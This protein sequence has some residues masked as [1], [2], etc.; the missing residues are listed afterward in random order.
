MRLTDAQGRPLVQSE[1]NFV[2]PRL[3][4]DLGL[5]IDP[6]LLFKSKEAR[7]RT[8][9][10]LLIEVFARAIRAQQNGD[11]SE[12]DRLVD[13]PEVDEIGFGYSAKRIKGSGMGRSLNRLVAETLAG[14]PALL[15]RGVHHLEEL[16]LLSTHI[17]PDRISDMT[18][19]ILKEELARYTVEQCGL[20]D[21]PVSSGVPLPHVFDSESF[22]WRDLY[23]DLPLDPST[24]RALLFVP[25]RMVRVLPWINY[26]EYAN[27]EFRLFLRAAKE[28]APSRLQGGRRGGP[29]KLEVVAITRRRLDVLDQYVARKEREQAAAEPDLGAEAPVEPRAEALVRELAEIP[30][31]RENA[32]RYQRTTLA[33]L[34]HL[35][36]PELT[37]GRL[38]QATIHGT[39]RRDIVFTNESDKSFWQYVRLS[40][41]N[42]LVMF[43][44]KNVQAVTNPHINQVAT[45]LG[46]RIGRFGV[47]L[48]RKPAQR[49]QVLKTISVFN[50]SS[51]RKVVLVIHDGDLERML[52]MKDRGV[53]PT[54]HIQELYRE[55][56][57]RLQ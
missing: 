17:G 51:P 32:S 30:P 40:Y 36:E 31:G 38:E 21:I 16:Q 9:H 18:A 15:E 52:R 10:D 13:F 44:A 25:R 8:F 11:R 39:E 47:I 53:A 19:N 49:A 37:G 46:D 20:W 7:L 33:I 27:N 1:V 22:R 24:G 55:F 42:W 14:S 29:T 56:K 43:E 3:D 35:F 57:L 2:V 34:N 41:G 12:L 26:G 54:K 23:V 5:C 28:T 4:R 6:F 45:Y 50:D 48:A